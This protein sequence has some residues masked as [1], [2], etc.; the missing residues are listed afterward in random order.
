MAEPESRRILRKE[1][2]KAAAERR[3]AVYEL[4][5]TR[6]SLP[7][8]AEAIAE[9]L[10]KAFADR[11]TT[12]SVLR[13]QAASAMV[14]LQMLANDLAIYEQRVRAEAAEKLA[15]ATMRAETVETYVEATANGAETDGEA[16][17]R[18]GRFFLDA[19]REKDRTPCVSF[20]ESEARTALNGDS[21]ARLFAGDLEVLLDD[22]EALQRL[23]NG[24]TSSGLPDNGE[25]S[26]R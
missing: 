4:R 22:S 11:N 6:R 20:V 10:R 17:R 3:E 19:W 9:S 26:G 5:L 1:R 25:G 2:E 13:L 21:M 23:R 15:T 12:P 18:R 7:E 14:G 8:R 16:A 24:T